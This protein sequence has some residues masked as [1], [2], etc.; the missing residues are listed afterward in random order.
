[1]PTTETL[2]W[3]QRLEVLERDYGFY[4]TTKEEQN[5]AFKAIPF[6][7][8]LGGVGRHLN[9]ILEYQNRHGV[10]KPDRAVRR[11]TRDMGQYRLDA[12]DR[13]AGLL[14][15]HHALSEVNP[16]L[17]I[18]IVVD[19]LDMRGL[20]SVVQ[21]ARIR[22]A[23]ATGN[24]T[25]LRGGVKTIEGRKRLVTGYD[26]ETH[27]AITTDMLLESL[28]EKTVHQIRGLVIP[29]GRSHAKRRDF[30]TGMLHSSESH[31]VAR[32]I[33]RDLLKAA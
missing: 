20:L 33:V 2:D 1:M 18:G 8:E 6:L 4:P 15:V 28:E 14:A 22:R 30:W 26:I 25:V 21:Y 9:E 3:Q 27:D 12:I 13:R 11:V 31:A 19:E 16:R 32:P 17:E 29:A 10:E 7:S 24:D 23:Y 5:T